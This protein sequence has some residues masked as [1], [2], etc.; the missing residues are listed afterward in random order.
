MDFVGAPKT[1]YAIPPAEGRKIEKL[2]NM[3]FREHYAE[4]SSFLRHKMTLISPQVLKQHNISF[5][6]ITQE[7]GEF[8]VS[9]SFDKVSLKLRNSF[10]IFLQKLRWSH[11][12]EAWSHSTFNQSTCSPSNLLVDHISIWLS[13]RLQ[14]WLQRRWEHQLRFRY[15]LLHPLTFMQF[16]LL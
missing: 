7:P 10:A 15:V 16:W 6:K 13:C 4:C 8:M 9:R 5:N 3:T 11:F 1:W 14:S 2:A 12:S